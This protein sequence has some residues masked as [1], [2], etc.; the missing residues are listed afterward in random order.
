M[1][2]LR[3][4][5]FPE[6]IAIKPSTPA[7]CPG[8]LAE[9]ELGIRYETL[10]LILF[11]LERFMTTQE[12]SDKLSIEEQQVQKVKIKWVSTEHKRR[13]P[14]APKIG[15]RTAGADFRLAYSNY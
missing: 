12:I 1:I 11:G 15:Y 7:L 4:L 5:D 9:M 14:L 13:M 8:R 6:E 10:D 2:W 3:Y